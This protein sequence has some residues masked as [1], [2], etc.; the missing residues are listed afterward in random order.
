MQD[1]NSKY[2]MSINIFTNI[3]DETIPMKTIYERRHKKLK[4]WLTSEKIRRENKVEANVMYI[5]E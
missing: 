2:N 4:I 1:V 3:L 5:S